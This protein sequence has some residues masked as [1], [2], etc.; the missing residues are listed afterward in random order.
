MKLKINVNNELNDIIFNEE[1]IVVYLNHVNDINELNDIIFNEDG[2]VV[3][4]NHVNDINEC[5]S[6][7]EMIM[8]QLE[9][10]KILLNLSSANPLENSKQVKKTVKNDIKYM[11]KYLKSEPYQIKDFD[12]YEILFS[13]DSNVNEFKELLESLNNLSIDI[14]D[15]SDGELNKLIC[16]NFKSEPIIINKRY[17]KIKN[18]KLNVYI[19]TI[20]TIKEIKES[21][22]KYNLSPF[23]QLML[24]YDFVK[25]RKY[26]EEIEN[27]GD[28]SRDLSKVLKSENIVCLG[29]SVLLASICDQLGIKN[30]VK[31]YFPTTGNIG[32]ATFT[33]YI[34]DFKYN[35]RNYFE[36]DPTFDSNK[37]NKDDANR[38]NNFGK[39]YRLIEER[40]KKIGLESTCIDNIDRIN[41]SYDDIIGETS[42]L[43]NFKVICFLDKASKVYLKLNEK[44]SANA[45][46]N[47]KAEDVSNDLLKK[48]KDDLISIY[49]EKIKPD[50]FIKAFYN[51]RRVEHS[52]NPNRYE[53]SYKDVMQALDTMQTLNFKQFNQDYGLLNANFVESYLKELLCQ[54]DL[55]DEKLEDKIY[56]DSKRM[57]L[58][59]VLRKASQKRGKDER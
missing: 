48:I 12:E 5:L 33:A 59:N 40:N 52:I 28:V 42:P 24:A 22:V 58:I 51:V 55:K 3:Y 47:L 21:I 45:I 56:Y 1:G 20:N 23:E 43:K 13:S 29:Y 14:S 41:K 10:A 15:L 49:N 36:F 38:Y 16:F 53:L 32:H 9:R 46:K 25:A 4:I 27:S 34:K 50:S 35:I 19:E 7:K 11:K 44:D 8:K 57:E 37:G 18:V 26:N 6:N 2:I 17:N 39:N 31:I 54:Y 30:D